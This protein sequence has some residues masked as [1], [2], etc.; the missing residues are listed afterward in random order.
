MK[1]K[2]QTLHDSIVFSSKILFTEL[3]KS[4]AKPFA[5]SSNGAQYFWKRRF[6]CF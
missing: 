1:K 3:H 4:F 2:T 5:M 6:K